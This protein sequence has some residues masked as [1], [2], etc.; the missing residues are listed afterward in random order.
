MGNAFFLVSLHRNCKF[1]L[2]Q[3]NRLILNPM[4]LLLVCCLSLLWPCGVKAQEWN[5][6]LYREIERS[7]VAPTFP[8]RDFDIRKYGAK[9]TASARQNQKALN[10]AIERCSKAGGGRVVVP[11]GVWQTGALRLLSGVNL[12]LEE[13]AVLQFAFQP[14][15]YPLVR[16]HW[17]GLDIM[18]Y[19]PCIYAYQARDIAITGSGTIDGG[20]TKE[21]WWPWCGAAK[22]GYVEGQT[23]QAQNM[24]Y[25]G[26]V[27][28]FDVRDA[29]G[30]RLSNRNMLL[31]MA[32][33]GVV[34]EARRFGPGCGMRPQLVNFYE[35]ENILMEGVTLLRSPFWVIH[36]TLSRNITIR[37]CKIINN[38]PNGDGC[39]P[40][41]CENVLIERCIFHTGDDCIAIKS[42]RNAD[43]RR[44]ARP[45]RNIIVR[46]CTMEDG[47][48]GVVIGSEI[49]G[50]VENVFAED[51]KMDSP[52]LDR[53]LRIKTNTCRGGVT[54]GIYMRN[55]EVG[56]CREA[57]MRIN[58]Q[59]EPKE[60]SQRG[61]VPTVRDVYMENVTSRKSRYGVLINGLDS[62]CNIYN[63]RLKDCR[64]EG[65][66]DQPVRRTGLSRDVR[67]EQVVINGQEVTDQGLPVGPQIQWEEA[68]RLAQWLVSSEMERTP[69]PYYLDFTDPGKRP[70]G[71]WS[72][73]M[74]I[75]LEAMLD[76]YLATGDKKILDYIRRYAEKMIAD[77]GSITGYKMEDYNLDNVR[78]GRFIRRMNQL[79]PTLQTEGTRKAVGT[80]RQQLEKQPRTK[81]GVWWHKQI[82]HDQVWLDGI[83]MGLPFYTLTA[84]D[85]DQPRQAK[86]YYDDAVEQIRK[87]YSRTYDPGTGLWKHAWDEAH[88][89]FWANPET[90][91]SRHTWARALGWFSM[92]MVEVLDVLPQDYAPRAEVERMFRQVMQAVVKYQDAAS[93]V[94]YD[95]MDVKDERNYLESTASSMFAY[96]LLKGAR[97]GY[98]DEA[99]RQAG[100]KAYQGI[101]KEFLRK[102]KDGKLSLTR[103]CQ[104]SGLGPEKSPNRDG[105]FEYYMSEPIRDNDAK[106]VG[107]FIWAS[108]E[109]DMIQRGEVVEQRLYDFVVPRDGSFRE[110][111]EAANARTDTTQRFR[112]F[113]MRGEYK[114]PTK[115]TTIGGDNQEYG[116]PRTRLSS[117]KVSLIGEERDATVLV[118]TT[119]PTTWDNGF[120]PAC[121]LEGIGNGDVLILEKPCVRTYLQDITLRNGMDDRTGRNIVLHDRGDLTIC[122]NVRLWAYQDTYVSNNQHGRYYFRGGVLR[123]RTD[124]ICGKGDVYF[125]RVT[126]QQCGTAGYICAPSVPRKFGY[127]MQQCYIQQETPD[128]TYYLGRPWGSATPTASW[129][130]THVD[131]SPITKDK[132][133]FNAWADMGSKGWPARFAEYNTYL[134]TGE[135]LDLTGRRS[136]WTDNDGNKHPN[137]PVLTAEEAAALTLENVMGGWDPTADAALV[138]SPGKVIRTC[139]RLTWDVSPRALL[140]AI[141]RN[142]KVV[143]FTI[144]N[145]YVI[146]KEQK[147]DEWT[148]RAANQMGGLD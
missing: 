31:W 94:W 133:G 101:V 71:K 7:I 55:V 72:Y 98:L 56:E 16:T 126:F 110:A 89:M 42:G 135:V 86:R 147:G 19:S 123:G 58:L 63:V 33:H 124:Y 4:G 136:S 121:P 99:C 84:R 143:D 111:I 67:F 93:G 118:N 128:V 10:K 139:N 127:V 6:Q 90:G 48:G 5:E 113:V 21:T 82:Y 116:D 14:E 134:T 144:S 41:S 53:V 12:V 29:G 140:Y 32:D 61:F 50:G 114:I 28:T 47:H 132:K 46:G 39:D 1:V 37:G 23:P 95:V 91:Q 138:A 54:R 141:C 83:F 59:Y 148:V 119:P 20:G 104:V 130:S 66:T 17:E 57:V 3:M 145:S 22:Y 24:P 76:V 2:F 109:M 77:D 26:D 27:R 87:T 103:C 146:K 34:Q 69:E 92:A 51:C 38:G 102:D 78:T 142:G 97:M 52:N 75:E 35:C 117:P 105:S 74:G 49:S 115:G 137:N 120:G 81:E 106:G 65:V 80:I 40:E 79:F 44:T 36:P 100:V 70:E 125:D 13:G 131:C 73:V 25:A 8:D 43:G 18:N 62:A 112:I 107:P 45:S 15:L 85:L 60:M 64:F 122:N 129:I 96:C 68:G 30:Q 108:L 9:T 88:S 11:S